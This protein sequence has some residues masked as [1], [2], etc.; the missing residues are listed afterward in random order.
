MKKM[1][2][3]AWKKAGK[4]RFQLPV[5]LFTMI[6]GAICYFL[7]YLAQ[8]LPWYYA[9]SESIYSMMRLFTLSFDAD[10]SA[11]GSALMKIVQFVLELDKWVALLFVGTAVIRLWGSIYQKSREKHMFE[12]WKQKPEKTLIIGCNSENIQ[13][14]SSAKKEDNAVLFSD[15]G[16]KSADACLNLTDLPVI[17][18]DAIKEIPGIVKSTLENEHLKSTIIINT[19]DEL[20]NLTLCKRI[21]E[22]IQSDIGSSQ[23][24]LR[25]KDISSAESLALEKSIIRKL[26]RLRVVV[27]GSRLYEDVYLSLQEDSV[28]ILQ[29]KN[30]YL[31][32]SCSFVLEHPLTEILPE[33]WLVS[34]CVE[35]DAALNVVLLGFGDTNRNIY[36]VHRATNQFVSHVEGQMPVQKKVHYFVFDKEQAEENALN[37]FDFR[38]EKDFLREIESGRLA[39]EDYLPLPD[40][41]A[42]TD[43]FKMDLNSPD[44]Y[45]QLRSIVSA[46]PKTATQIVIAFGDD[47]TNI[48]MAQKLAE[49]QREWG[50]QHVAVYAKVRD[51]RVTE[52]F[53]GAKHPKFIP[54][55]DEGDDIY[56]LQAIRQN[57]IMNMARRRNIMYTMTSSCISDTNLMDADM[58]AHADYLW[59]TMDADKQMSNLF[60]ILSIRFKLQLMGLDYSAKEE[61]GELRSNQEYMDI[62]ANGDHLLYAGKQYKGIPLIDNPGTDTKS[63]FSKNILRKNLTVQEHLRWN[64]FMFSC[65]FIP[66][67]KAQMESGIVKDYTL[68]IHGNLTT[69]E[70]LFRF[71]K[72]MAEYKQTSESN[73]DV[74]HYDYQLMDQAWC[75]LHENGL[76]VYKKG[77]YVH[78]A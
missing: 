27:F 71:R 67:T 74:I 13:T 21:I 78:Q 37:H 59:Y 56:G 5:L 38:Y 3:N 30:K 25:Q 20:R 61:K 23:K 24:K 35:P 28:G 22:I 14:L 50:T 47:L 2:K 9:L 7:Y 46:S 42:E 32:S 58:E 72:I 57:S 60:D 39:K 40:V 51:K 36:S 18:A 33:E 12:L 15:T 65:G 49:K 54:I 62:Y 43:F 45:P 4:L 75:F 26:N 77:K 66:A 44:F 8:P 53:E 41:A 16:S 64:A 63:D 69:W 1:L 11:N 17:S 68:R 6:S 34:G 29:Y 76:H 70:G 52:L 10:I 55:C 19:H 48:D 73:T 31:D